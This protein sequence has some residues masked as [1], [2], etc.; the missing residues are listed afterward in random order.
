VP[1]ERREDE[2]LKES[3]QKE[4]NRLKQP[5]LLSIMK[6]SIQKQLKFLMEETEILKDE[7]LKII[8]NNKELNIIYNS[9][10]NQK[11]IARELALFLIAK[12]KELGKIERKQLSAICGLAPVACDSGKIKGHRY[13]IGGRKEAQS[14]KMIGLP[15]HFSLSVCE[16]PND[17]REYEIKSKLYFHAMNLIRF[18]PRFK[19]KL[20]SFVIRGKNKKLALVALARKQII[21]LNAIVRNELK[22]EGL[23][24]EN[25]LKEKG[26]LIENETKKQEE[27]R[28][29]TK[30]QQKEKK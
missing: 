21:I 16:V 24:V 27:T 2:D 1:T 12:L 17:R 13:T 6:V 30:K 28:N 14:R 10:I 15:N 26:L 29:I 4:K 5:N 20:N 7:V 3:I 25:E 22:K 23:L 9:L 19:N 11:G 8:Q 18:D